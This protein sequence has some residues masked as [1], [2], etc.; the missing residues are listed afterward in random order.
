M[1]KGFG[2][3]GGMGAMAA[4]AFAAAVLALG[5]WI[6]SKR[7]GPE[8]AGQTTV[9][10]LPERDATPENATLVPNAVKGVSVGPEGVAATEPE[11]APQAPAFDEVR[12][13]SD[14][15]TVIAGRAAPGSSVAV[16]KDGEEIATATADGSG[17]FATLAMIPPDGKGHVLTLLGQDGETKLAS[18]EEIIL[19]PTAAPLQ[20][21]EADT[22]PE[23]SPLALAE[24][25]ADPGGEAAA[26]EGAEPD[27]ASPD[28]VQAAAEA[29]D[30]TSL[31]EAEMT[32]ETSADQTAST[33]APAGER[34][35]A[36]TEPAATAPEQATPLAGTATGEAEEAAESQ[37]TSHDGSAT[38]A[39]ASE[40]ATAEQ[41][42][43][44]GGGQLDP[45]ETGG[46]QGS[47]AEQEP[48]AGE[49]AIA[50]VSDL[51]Q[52]TPLSGTGT[53][54]GVNAA[55]E[56]EPTAGE[57]ETVSDPTQATPLSGTGTAEGAN[58][59]PEQEPAAGEGEIAIGSDPS[60][61]TSLSD[62]GSA[63]GAGS[64]PDQD[65][66]IEAGED[67]AIGTAPAQA[68]PLAGTGTG[69]GSAGT[70]TGA[71][72]AGTGTG[73]GDSTAPDQGQQATSDTPAQATLLA[74]TGTADAATGA[75][76]G[77]AS[78]AQGAPTPNPTTDAPSL[79][80]RD[81]PSPETTTPMPTEETDTAA[82]PARPSA[83][84]PV[85]KSTAEGVERLD[86]A[87]PQVMTN[88][89][90]D[91]I[92]YSDQGDVQLAGRAQPD[93]SE[94]RVYLN[95]NAVISLP[96]DQEG[97]WR[98]D[99]PNVDEGVYTL[100]VDE[101]SRAGDVTSRVE[102]PFKRESP[103]VLAAAT[104]G[105][106]GPLSAVTVQKGDT[107]WAISRDRYGDPLLYVKVFEANSANIRDPDLIY[108]GQVFDLPEE[109]ATE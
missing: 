42:T 36:A 96:V 11:A 76:D 51:N 59:A 88:V 58:S 41:E 9:A 48:A 73:A 32:R 5:A 31:A 69:A 106:T 23:Q 35:E 67:L 98:G 68:T 64:A 39:A 15:M 18:E 4:G 46:A 57:G 13:E 93:T 71:G 80:E 54:E 20:M 97:R 100:R 34:N 87:P 19:T 82:A 74:G 1:F 38:P 104:E 90:L 22:T 94:V 84:A 28:D 62:T 75:A 91:T 16:L 55:P 3:F 99:L 66:A 37:P 24:E 89:A 8:E 14:G 81:A 27:P 44:E 52:A 86:T 6:G 33:N 12:R 85:L 108:P 49:G 7:S 72:L 17:K 77:T 25:G 40:T 78:P 10:V 101:L 53:A 47:A 109:P 26:D 65:Q 63:E 21:A 83:P 45:L 60:Q 50:N 79:A 56:Q 105:L 30:V 70:G 2:R 43:I 107:L 92:G 29:S 103:E 102:T 95:N 61:A